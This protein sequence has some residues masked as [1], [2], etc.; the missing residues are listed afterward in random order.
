MIWRHRTTLK[1]YL[2]KA[3]QHRVCDTS[4]SGDFSPCEV[5][6]QRD[7]RMKSCSWLPPLDQKLAFAKAAGKKRDIKREDHY[8]QNVNN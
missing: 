3:T 1:P 6:E 7:R 4:I 8:L 5:P 2:A